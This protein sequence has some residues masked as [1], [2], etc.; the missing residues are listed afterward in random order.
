[1]PETPAFFV[2]AATDENKES[3]YTDFAK[4]CGVPVPPL[5]KRVYSIVFSHDGEIWNAT[6]GETMRGTRSSSRKVKGHAVEHTI[7]VSDPALVLAI[8][9]GSPFM[10]VTNHRIVG[11]VGSRWENP[12][13]AG[14]PRS[15]TR[16]LG[17]S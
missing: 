16:F 8:F 13:L 14:E 3:V 5:E 15:V 4:W 2:P 6:V 9:P 10:V 1:M 12:F 17:P 11:N 7:H